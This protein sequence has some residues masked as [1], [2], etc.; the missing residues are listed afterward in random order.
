MFASDTGR[1]IG[2]AFTNS[3]GSLVISDIGDLTVN[4]QLLW[5]ND[6]TRTVV[7][8]PVNMTATDTASTTIS[9]NI[10]NAV[11]AYDY[12]K[13][14]FFGTPTGTD[15]RLRIE[16]YSGPVTTFNYVPTIY[17]HHLAQYI[18]TTNLKFP[19]Y[20]SYNPWPSTGVSVAT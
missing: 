10:A 7:Y 19:L 18:S 5:F 14:D 17:G 12:Q 2:L 3:L 8:A 4:W 6:K 16:I 13:D 1:K 15:P 11:T 20:G 9:L